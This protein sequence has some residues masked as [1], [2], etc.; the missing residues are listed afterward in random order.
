MQMTVTREIFEDVCQAG[1]L[2]SGIPENFGV[3]FFKN[4]SVHESLVVC[5]PKNN[6]D[7]IFL[8]IIIS[9]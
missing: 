7:R 3:F 9:K 5:Y 6:T 4:C 1:L 2:G 8:G